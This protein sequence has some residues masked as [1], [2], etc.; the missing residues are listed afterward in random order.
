MPRDDALRDLE[1]Y[2]AAI[3]VLGPLGNK[4]RAAQGGFSIGPAGAAG[5]HVWPST[6]GCLV[7]DNADQDQLYILSTSSIAPIGAQVGDHILQPSPVDGGRDPGDAIG[8]LHRWIRPTRNGINR[9]DAAVAL[10]MDASYVS[11]ELFGLGPITGLLDLET[12]PE[13]GVG[14]RVMKVGRTTGL[15]IGSITAI[16]VT[17]DVSYENGTMRFD[18]L[19][20]TDCLALAGDNGAILV[21][22]RRRAI[23][24]FFAHATTGSTEG[25]KSFF[26]PILAVL[27]ELN[28]SLVMG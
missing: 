17:L 5:Q 28:G 4:S 9:V 12:L 19:I 10:V 20:D 11:P 27:Y 6:L 14:I 7:R 24:M 22:E 2:G 3:N 18:N 15:T 25:P 1:Q 8:F 16:G 26:M 23:G 13:F 21:D